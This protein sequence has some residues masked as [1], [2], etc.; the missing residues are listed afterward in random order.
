MAPAPLDRADGVPQGVQPASGAPGLCRRPRALDSWFSKA[1]ASGADFG[2]G[3][4]Y[5]GP[6]LLC[7][8]ENNPGGIHSRSTGC[9]SPPNPLEQPQPR[10]LLPSSPVGAIADAPATV[11]VRNKPSTPGQIPALPG[12]H[13][14]WA[15]A[16]SAPP[17]CRHAPDGPLAG[18]GARL[19]HLATPCH[20]GQHRSR[21]RRRDPPRP[22][23]GAAI[24]WCYAKHATE[25]RPLSFVAFLEPR[26]P[27]QHR[28]ASPPPPGP[29][30]AGC[31]QVIGGLSARVD[32]PDRAHRPAAPVA[33]LITRE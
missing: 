30:G 33:C 3:A 31:R 14:Q 11:E 29:Q 25:K 17:L 28:N 8:W 13:P 23:G 26:K 4:L 12:D 32:R 10:L 6:F 15:V 21:N 7:A 22:R 18:A 16:P 9:R 20:D 24:F 27:P 1:P 5:S 19:F 2:L